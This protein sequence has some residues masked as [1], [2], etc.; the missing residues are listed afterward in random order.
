MQGGRH[1]RASTVSQAVNSLNGDVVDEVSLTRP[2][3]GGQMNQHRKRTLA[4][5]CNIH[6]PVWYKTSGFRRAC[7]GPPTVPGI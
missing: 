5:F 2:Q 3:A 6:M 4:L 1:V 7:S